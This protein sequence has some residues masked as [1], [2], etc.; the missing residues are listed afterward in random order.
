MHDCN[1]KL[2]KNLNF[3]FRFE[4][5]MLRRAKFSRQHFVFV[6]IFKNDVKF[7]DFF[8]EHFHF[9]ALSLSVE[10]THS[11]N[12]FYFDD[13]QYEN[14]IVTIFEFIEFD[15]T[16]ILWFSWIFSNYDDSWKRKFRVKRFSNNVV[17]VWMFQQ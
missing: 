16:I 5:C 10:I 2:Q 15:A 12:F 4:I 1:S 13:N 6:E 11:L 7:D 3:W 14:C 17:N 9:F 8:H